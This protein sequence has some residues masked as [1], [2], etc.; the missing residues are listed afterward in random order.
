MKG[1]TGCT[2]PQGPAAPTTTLADVSG[3]GQESIVGNGV[4]PNLTVKRLS[5][6]NSVSL[7]SD[8]N[9]IQ[10]VGPAIESGDNVIPASFGGFDSLIT[11]SGIFQRTEDFVSFYV[12]GRGR[13]S[14]GATNVNIQVFVA[15]PSPNLANSGGFGVI[16]GDDL[17]LVSVASFLGTNFLFDFGT[18][19]MTDV[20]ITWYVQGQF[21]F[22]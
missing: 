6:G 21:R 13:I 4:G 15:F 9:E 5:G 2:G 18:P 19:S 3:Q 10:I 12:H 16:K 20:D 1:A 14:S 11:T 17:N 8:A 7:N 22:M